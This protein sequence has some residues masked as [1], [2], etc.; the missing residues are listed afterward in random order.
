MNWTMVG[1]IADAGFAT[2]QANRGA[3]GDAAR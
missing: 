2:S 3:I 1:G